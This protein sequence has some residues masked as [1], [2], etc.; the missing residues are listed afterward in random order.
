M[1]THKSKSNIRFD[2]MITEKRG[3][4][5]D[6]YARYVDCVRSFAEQLVPFTTYRFRYLSRDNEDSI[7]S[8]QMTKEIFENLA[9]NPLT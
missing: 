4:E 8:I 1:T 5:G 3:A 6:E 2:F 9:E 7:Y